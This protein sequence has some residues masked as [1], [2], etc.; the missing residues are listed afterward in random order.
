MGFTL[1]G[2]ILGG[3]FSAIGRMADYQVVL[4]A[5]GWH[6][7]GVLDVDDLAAIQAAIDAKNAAAVD[8]ADG[9]TAEEV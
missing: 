1:K 8:N 6:G 3:L 2:F 5:A 4:N 9:E 7:R